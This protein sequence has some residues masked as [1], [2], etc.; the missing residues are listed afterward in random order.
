MNE[1]R[2]G[3]FEAVLAFAQFIPVRRAAE[4][5]GRGGGGICQ[6]LQPGVAR[7]ALDPEPG[8]FRAGARAVAFDAG[9][10]VVSAGCVTLVA[11]PQGDE[12]WLEFGDGA[13]ASA[14]GI[15]LFVPESLAALE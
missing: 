10:R 15:D 6:H 4:G 7:D 12:P 9:G 3:G 1:R 14:A 13:G 8:G 5:A 11:E 2:D